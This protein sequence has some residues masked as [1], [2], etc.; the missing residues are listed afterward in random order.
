MSLGDRIRNF[1]SKKN[2]PELSS[3][4][5]FL[6]ENKGVEGFIEPKTSTNPTTLLLVDREGKHD[7]APVRDADD[8]IA[9]CERHGIP[10]YDA[11]VIGYPRR[12]HDYLKGRRTTTSVDDAVL[13]DLERRLNE[14]G[15]DTP[16]N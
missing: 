2:N 8:A 1:F 16:N 6:K 15:P 5:A 10:V 14:S 13:A 11:A 4:E 7:R 9:F 12:M 3:L